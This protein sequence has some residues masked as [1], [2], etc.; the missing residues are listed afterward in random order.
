METSPVHQ[1]IRLASRL[2]GARLLTCLTGLAGHS[3]LLK[4]YPQQGYLMDVDNEMRLA[5][6][7][8]QQAGPQG[9]LCTRT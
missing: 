6:E 7:S 2:G 3:H 1:E 8:V 5:W 4:C 9:M